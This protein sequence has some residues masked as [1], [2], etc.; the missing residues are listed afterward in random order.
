MSRIAE[1]RPYRS[2]LRAQQADGT[3]AQI[4]DAA[5]RVMAGG[6]ATLSV[7]A[8]AREAGVSVPTVYRHFGTKAD[9]LGALHPHL[10]RRAGMQEV[11]GPRSMDKLREGIHEIF[12]RVDR[13]GALDDLARAA[14][15]SP[16]ADEGRRLDMPRRLEFARALLDTA[17]PKL[18]RA[19]RDRLARAIVVLLSSSSLRIWREFLG[20]SVDQ[21]TDDATWIVRAAVAGATTRRKDR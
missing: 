2:E 15:V 16:A 1:S 10:M 20:V 18:S 4:L 14:M 19:D 8:V 12:S 13:L 9:L 21:A 5:I 3:R 11:V 17:E 7:P 6:V